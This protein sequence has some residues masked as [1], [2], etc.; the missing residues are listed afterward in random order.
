MNIYLSSRK[1]RP[2][3]GASD[4]FHKPTKLRH[5]ARAAALPQ[6]KSLHYS[7]LPA[8]RPVAATQQYAIRPSIALQERF[9]Y[10]P[11]QD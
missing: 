7:D 6:E 11:K 4:G 2:A 10:Q 8:C 9:F 3:G 1:M 5:T